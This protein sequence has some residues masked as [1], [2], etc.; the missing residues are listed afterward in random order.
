M[1][2][3]EYSRYDGTALSDLVR[4]GEITPRELAATALK[5]IGA[6][7]PMLNA[8]IDIYREQIDRLDEASLPAGP[9]R[10]VP[11]VVKRIGISEK[12]KPMGDLGTRLLQEIDRPAAAC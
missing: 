9:F 12:G 8:V 4:K 5:A 7:D 11:F 1:N 6:V 2:L 3:A 10:G